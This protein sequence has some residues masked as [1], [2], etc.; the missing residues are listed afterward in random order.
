ML[1]NRLFLR[2]KIIM[3]QTLKVK[4]VISMTLFVAVA[5][6]PFSVLVNP[7][8][9]VDGFVILSQDRIEKSMTRLL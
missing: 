1:I 3:H 5:Y 4:K 7:Q 2:Y 6:E 8:F 9:S